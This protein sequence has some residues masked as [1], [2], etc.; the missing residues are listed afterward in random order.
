M[1]DIGHFVHTLKRAPRY[2]IAVL[3]VTFGLTVFVDLVIAVNIGVVLATLMFMHRMSETVEVRRHHD[4]HL[5]KELGADVASQ[6]PAGVMVYMIDGPFFFGASENFERAMN[7]INED[8]RVLILR[9]G[10]VPYVDVTGLQTLQEVVEHFRKRH[11]RVIL[12]DI[13]P[14]IRRKLDKAGIFTLLGEENVYQHLAD[15]PFADLK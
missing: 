11:V 3:L 1:S 4:E 13:S 7:S 8:P 2:D 15:I 14:R 5:H 12:S 6:I 10:E 9:F